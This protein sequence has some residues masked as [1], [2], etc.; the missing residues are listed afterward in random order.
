ML[1]SVSM[2][3]ISD[4]EHLEEAGVDQDEEAQL[5]K[6]KL[7]PLSV[8]FVGKRATKVTNFQ[9]YKKHARERVQSPRTRLNGSDC[10]S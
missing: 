3:Q 8:V 1:L 2:V 4:T 5:A 10:N 9:C 6:N 7:F